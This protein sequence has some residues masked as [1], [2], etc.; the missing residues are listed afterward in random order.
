MAAAFCKRG[1]WA[2]CCKELAATELWSK[3]QSAD[4]P[5]RQARCDRLCV[6]VMQVCAKW[7]PKGQRGSAE[8][9]SWN[10][11]VKNWHKLVLVVVGEH[12]GGQKESLKYLYNATKKAP[13]SLHSAA[14]ALIDEIV[15]G[16]RHDDEGALAALDGGALVAMMKLLNFRVKLLPADAPARECNNL[17]QKMFALMGRH[18]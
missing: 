14:S 9:K 10:S 8:Q 4:P 13:P 18:I 11:M 16:D 17:Q 12:T 5:K 2:K 6:I 7:K 15:L 1:E 3:V